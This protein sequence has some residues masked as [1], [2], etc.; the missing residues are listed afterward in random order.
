MEE[1]IS[2]DL[3]DF[4]HIL[5]KRIKLILLI[6]IL[7]TA[8]SGFLSYY[9][10][11]PTYEA[12]TTIIVGKADTSSSDKSK[13]NYNYNDIMMYQNL[14]KTY[15]EIGKSNAVAEKAA[16]GLKDITAEQ[17]QKSV[18]VTPQ[19]DTQIVQFKAQSNNPRQAY[20]MLNAVANSFMQ[21][22]TRIYPGENIKIMDEAEVP[23]KSIKP[24]KLLNIAIA[25]FIGLMASVGLSFLLEYMD[26]TLKTEQDINKYLGL[27]VIGIIPKDFGKY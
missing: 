27:P 21:E 19:V 7:S 25:F 23:S 3:G 16:A 22:A 1:E 17:I 10:I 18:T 2:L 20:L 12:S 14:I 9:V 15:A 4:I 5:R 13:N 6:T 24:R 26:N 8:V 11:K